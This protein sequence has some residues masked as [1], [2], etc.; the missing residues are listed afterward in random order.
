MVLASRTVVLRLRRQSRD[1]G[2]KSY[3]IWT[4]VKYELNNH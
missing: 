1:S 4:E 2:S 3:L